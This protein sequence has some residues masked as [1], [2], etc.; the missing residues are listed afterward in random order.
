MLAGH[1]YFFIVL[2]ET[3]PITPIFTLFFIVSFF[4]FFYQNFIKHLAI[5]RLPRPN[6]YHSSIHT[7][8]SSAFHPTNETNHS[9]NF[10]F[11]PTPPNHPPQ[12]SNKNTHTRGQKT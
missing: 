4:F 9:Q 8:H 1:A 3:S 10:I 6:V 11:A 5:K 2:L 7:K 12:K